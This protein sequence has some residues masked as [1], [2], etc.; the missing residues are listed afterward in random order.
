MQA[1]LDQLQLQLDDSVVAAVGE[2]VLHDI[3]VQVCI[4]IY[5]SVTIGV[6]EDVNTVTNQPYYE[7]PG[8]SQVTELRE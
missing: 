6:L 4:N 8:C 7:I 3:A 5:Y 1:A 2:R